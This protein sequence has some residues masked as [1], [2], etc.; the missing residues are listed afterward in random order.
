VLRVHPPTETATISSAAAVTAAAAA[1]AAAA[2]GLDISCPQSGLSLS[3]TFAK[4][5]SVKGTIEQLKLSKPTPNDAAAE[6]RAVVGTLEGSW[7]GVINATCPQLVRS[8]MPQC[9]VAVTEAASM[10][11]D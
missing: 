4:D 5:H 9:L 1:A 7:I 6:A 10:C 11:L 3:L 2:G 8:S